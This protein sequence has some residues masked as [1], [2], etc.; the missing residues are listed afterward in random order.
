MKTQP[1]SNPST[2]AKS[3]CPKLKRARRAALKTAALSL[4][5]A[6]VIGGGAGIGWGKEIER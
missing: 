3:A 6:V 4:A 5:A 2:A 1:K